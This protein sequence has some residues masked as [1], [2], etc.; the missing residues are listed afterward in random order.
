M[1]MPAESG[2][3]FCP[4]TGKEQF[5]S[6]GDAR[7]VLAG[8]RRSGRFQGAERGRTRDKADIYTCRHCGHLHIGRRSSWVRQ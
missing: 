2:A 4:T 8:R 3:S 5:A 7:R 6:E 1:T